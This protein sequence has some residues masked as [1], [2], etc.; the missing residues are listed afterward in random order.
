MKKLFL[1]ALTLVSITAITIISAN[2][3]GLTPWAYMPY[4]TGPGT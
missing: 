4:I 2:A 1:I 3:G